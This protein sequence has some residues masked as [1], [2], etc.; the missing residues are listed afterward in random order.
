MFVCFLG[1]L[2]SVFTVPTPASQGS[3][4][5]KGVNYGNRFI[6]EDWMENDGNSIFGNHYGPSVNK[7][8]D[9]ERV[10]L[11]D[12]TDDRILRWLDDKVKEE[13]FQKMQQ[14]GVKLLRVPTGYWNWVDLGGATPNCPDNVA[15]RFRNLQSVKPYQYEPYLD[16]IYQYGSKYGIKIFM[17][18]HGAPGSQNGEIHS[19]CVTGP[20][21]NGKPTHYFNTDWN[22]EI[23]VNAIGKMSE[24]CKENYRVCWGVGVLNEPQP[25]RPAPSDDELHAFLSDYYHQAIQKA[26]ASLS[27]DTPVV[28]FSWTYDFWR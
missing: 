24:K 8:W 11:C 6:P 13:D 3:D 23:A 18:L 5:I 15:G 2:A 22:K 4:F 26:R 14:Y 12:V 7:P 21:N 9:V 1:T 17:E 28:L 16:K 27:W 20:E 25:S 10:S 19:G